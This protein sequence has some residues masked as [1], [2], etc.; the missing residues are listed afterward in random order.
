MYQG[1]I[2]PQYA[3]NTA[4]I[5]AV[6]WAWCLVFDDLGW[7]Y[8][9]LHQDTPSILLI[10]RLYVHLSLIICTHDMLNL[11][12]T[13]PPCLFALTCHVN[14]IFWSFS[15]RKS[16]ITHTKNNQMTWSWFFLISWKYFWLKLCNFLVQHV[17]NRINT[18]KLNI[19]TTHFTW[20]AGYIAT[21]KVQLA[22]I[23][24]A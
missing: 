7:K 16:Y 22:A 13:C 3:T 2:G 17:S 24:N 15:C 20:N 14:S 19:S 1:Y 9:N 4:D 11:F 18:K 5:H 12:F 8:G 21:L 6:A 23:S 10:S